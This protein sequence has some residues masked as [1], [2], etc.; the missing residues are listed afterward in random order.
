MSRPILLGADLFCGVGLVARGLLATQCAPGVQLVGFDIKVTT[1]YPAPFRQRD[2][3][4][5][6]A[7]EL[8][9]FDFIWASPPCLRD[10]IMRHAPGAKGHEHPD[11]ITPTRTLLEDWSDL[12]RQNGQPGLWVIENVMAADLRDPV[13]LHG[14]PFGLGVTVDNTRYHLE[15]KRKFETNWPLCA[16]YWG[17]PMP[18]PVV[19]VYGGHARVRSAKAGGRGTADF[20][21]H[22]HV[23][24]MSEAFGLERPRDEGLT[25]AEISQGIPPIYAEFVI[26]Q[27]HAHHFGYEL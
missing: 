24:I 2:V 21:G 19:G 4:T 12:K 14:A 23:D 17:D 10:T 25:G 27:L 8:A 3:L 26:D 1:K 5:M 9:L 20:V 16:P 11:L 15:R 7:A 22:S 18:K 13:V 6:T